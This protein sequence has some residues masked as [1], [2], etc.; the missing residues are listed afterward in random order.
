MHGLA[1]VVDIELRQGHAAAALCAALELVARLEGT[2]Y[3]RVLNLAQASLV[4]AWL[5]NDSGNEARALAVEGWPR[6]LVF[7][8]HIAV[9]SDALALLAAL[10]GH[11]WPTRNSR[12][13][14]DRPR[15]GI[16]PRVH[17]GRRV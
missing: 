8:G 17:R 1:C 14:D 16:S 12:T 2:R 5:A 15:Y 11:P 13:C 4:Q 9:W 3:R 7:Q 6:A 10:E